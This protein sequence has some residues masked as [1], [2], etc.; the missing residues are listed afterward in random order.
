[1]PLLRTAALIFGVV[2]LLAGLLFM[3]Q[4]SGI[5]P[6]PKSSFMITQSSWIWRGGLVALLGVAIVLASRRL[7]R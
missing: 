3:A 2:A 1:M 4:G 5:F 7:P 6:Y